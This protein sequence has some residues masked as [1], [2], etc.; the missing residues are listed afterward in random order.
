M[1]TTQIKD[2]LQNSS[3]Q[4]EQ[5]LLGA[6][7][8]IL[9]LSWIPVDN[10]PREGEDL[11]LKVSGDIRTGYY[12]DGQFCFDFGFIGDNSMDVTHYIYS[13]NLL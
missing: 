13:K 1:K 3:E 10:T 8:H 7:K 9:G 2:V 11:I 4:P 6:I 5:H 12:M